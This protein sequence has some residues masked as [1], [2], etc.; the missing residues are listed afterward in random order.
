M[1]QVIQTW[2][3]VAVAGSTTVAGL[4]RE[5]V[6][7]CRHRARRA[8]LERLVAGE[9]RCLR[10]VDRDADGAVIDITITEHE[11]A[12]V[13]QTFPSNLARPGE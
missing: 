12:D 1:I 7:L 10:V 2:A 11:P 13:P 9:A 4:V 5:L 6:A 8:S 3:V